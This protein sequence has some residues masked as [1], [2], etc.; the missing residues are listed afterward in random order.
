MTGEPDQPHRLQRPRSARVLLLRK[1]DDTRARTGPGGT[2]QRGMIVNAI[3][4]ASA[5]R[6]ERL[7]VC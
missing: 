3:T 7:D 4:P 6:A 1:L 5:I 2:G